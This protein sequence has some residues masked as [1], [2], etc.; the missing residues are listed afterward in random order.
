MKIALIDPGFGERSWHTFSQS[1]WS[2]II[3]HGL[4]GLSACLKDTG[5]HNVHLLDIRRMRGR[6]E[7]ERQIKASNPDVV[8]ITM[9][10]CDINMDASIVRTLKLLKPEIMTVVGGVHVS[11]DPEFVLK[12]PDYDYVIAG[13]GEITF[14]KL[15]QAL[16]HGE[17]FPR[18]S[19]G[20]RPNL[21]TLPF[22]DRELYPYRTVIELPNYEGIFKPPM[23]TMI[24]SRGCMYNCS[25]CAPHSKIHFGNGVR[26]RS[27]S[28]VIEELKNLHYRYCF[29]SAKFYD[30]TFTQKPE[31]VEEFCEQYASFGK[32]F[33]IQSRADLIVKH[34]ELI[35][36]LKKVGL[37][38][39][40]VGFES[41]SDR[42]LRFLRKGATG[43]INREAARIVKS[44][45][46]MLSASFMLGVPTETNQEVEETVSLSREIKPHLTSVA[47]FTPIPGNDL[48]IY[49]KKN[50]LVLN[51]DPEMWVEFSPEIPKVRGKDYEFLR[52]AAARIMGDRFGGKFAGRIIRYL[53][54]RTK[55]SYRLRNVLVRFYSSWVASRGYLW[56]QHLRQFM[57][58]L[59]IV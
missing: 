52:G 25:F 48:Y 51:D 18:F 8:G 6:E 22:I 3:H 29:N 33:W 28:N 19:W 21:D 12:N 15:V 56:V 16:E 59:K 46:V 30:Y 13:E 41:G 7:L 11:I 27:V 37:K 10:S 43:T 47:F 17:A 53:Y 35:I 34:P 57:H 49:C 31:W 1:H 50:D 2:S 42:V 38:L 26:F 55:Y 24:C 23:V 14:A 40:G 5:Y 32:S 58:R 36:K 9:R 45:G 4:C 39:I 44:A 54:V 20:E